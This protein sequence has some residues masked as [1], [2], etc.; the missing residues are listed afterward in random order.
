M[1]EYVKN[2]W[3]TSRLSSANRW[4]ASRLSSAN[5]WLASGPG[6]TTPR[7][8]AYVTPGPTRGFRHGGASRAHATHV[9]PLPASA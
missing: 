4:L 2:E 8:L 1:P 6:L 5:Q 9:T 7:N 3:P